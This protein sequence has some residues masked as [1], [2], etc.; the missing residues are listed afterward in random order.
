M[1]ELLAIATLLGGITALCFFWDRISAWLTGSENTNSHDISLYDEYKS[2]FIHNGVA[3]FYRQHD[4][5]GAFNEENWCSAFLKLRSKTALNE[6]RQQFS[7]EAVLFRL[8][9]IVM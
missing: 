6:N 1:E 2:L 7:F 5:L 4:F 8:E 9:C 3:E